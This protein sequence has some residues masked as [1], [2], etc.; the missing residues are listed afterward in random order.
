[1][2]QAPES[3]VE[4]AVAR[5]QYVDGEVTL[6]RSDSR[7]PASELDSGEDG[8]AGSEVIALLV[9]EMRNEMGGILLE[10]RVPAACVH[11]T[12]RGNRG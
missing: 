4:L 10:P 11:S 1:M 12:V 9:C 6:A 2:S 7:S 5:F 8:G 3:R